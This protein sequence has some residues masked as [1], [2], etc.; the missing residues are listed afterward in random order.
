MDDNNKNA[1]RRKYRS[2]N[3]LGTTDWAIS[4][5]DK[6]LKPIPAVSYLSPIRPIHTLS[7]VSG[8][9]QNA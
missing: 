7:D 1:R 4:L 6:G 8:G 3:F 9:H 2:L 5:D